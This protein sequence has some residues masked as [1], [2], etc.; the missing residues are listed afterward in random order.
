MKYDVAAGIRLAVLGLL[1]MVV[2]G[3]V[4]ID[5]FSLSLVS[6]ETMVTVPCLVFYGL[7]MLMTSKLR[8]YTG[9]CCGALFLL[10]ELSF[11]VAFQFVVG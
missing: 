8:G 11:F 1:P 5:S 10:V 2:A 9:D 4:M 6:L 7:Y 3:Y